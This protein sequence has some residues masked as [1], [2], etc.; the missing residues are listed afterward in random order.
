MTG[1]T[2]VTKMDMDS[3]LNAALAECDELN[4]SLWVDNGKLSFRA[5]AFGFPDSLRDTLRTHRDELFAVLSD[6]PRP[7]PEWV[8]FI[9]RNLDVRWFEFPLVKDVAVLLV[10]GR[11]YF[12]V[13]PSILVRFFTAVENRAASLQS[14]PVA[15]GAF[16]QVA[17]MLVDIGHWVDQHYR[18]DQISRAFANPLPLP[19]VP[20][21]P[22]SFPH[23]DITTASCQPSP[24]PSACAPKSQPRK[25]GRQRTRGAT[26]ATGSECE[27]LF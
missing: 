1:V 14:D 4:I 11:P 10:N 24:K 21:G 26:T 18:P 27:S 6:D 12:R 16:Q 17:A 19:T 20:R 3:P 15:F 5:G 22:L 23:D 7:T 13:T 2:S 9:A 25:K 8:P